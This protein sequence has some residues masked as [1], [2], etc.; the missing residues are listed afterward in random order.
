MFGLNRAVSAAV[1]AEVPGRPEMPSLGNDLRHDPHI[2]LLQSWMSLAEMQQRVIRTL[3]AEIQDT[4][5]FVEKEADDLSG[6]FQRLA[7]SAQQQTGRVES[8][9]HLA[10]S[11]EVE[12][13]PVPI[14]EIARLLKDTLGDVVAKI[15]MLSK[16]SMAMV[17]ALNEVSANIVNVE[18]CMAKLDQVN[19]TTNMLALN[20]RI[21]A[22][23]AGVAGVTFRVVADEVRELSKATQA[24]SVTMK[25]DLKAVIDG[26]GTS[27]TTL[28][29]VA[30]IDLSDNILAKDRLEVLLAAMVQRGGVLENIVAEAVKEAGLISAD[31]DGMITGLQFQDRARQR[32]EHV[33]DA[34][35]VIGEALEENKRTTASVAPQLLELA[36]ADLGWVAGLLDRFTMSEMRARFAAELLRG[37]PDAETHRHASPDDAKGSIELF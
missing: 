7:L 36:P 10:A 4:S 32:L 5:G 14:E 16:D 35:S 21:E 17:Y 24:L 18:K 30:T 20:A 12:D 27:N 13:R 28:H 23:R 33:V 19:S 29:R 6:R 37:T 22:E 1:V 11:I 9:T 31:V 25:E 3:I 8:L 26:I 34:L 2:D 15:L